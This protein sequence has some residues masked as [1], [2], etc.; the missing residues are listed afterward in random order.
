M[1]TLKPGA[2]PGKV[3]LGWDSFISVR[4]YVPAGKS[5]CAQSKKKGKEA[6]FSQEEIDLAVGSKTGHGGCYGRISPD[7]RAE[8]KRTFRIQ[9]GEFHVTGSEGWAD[10]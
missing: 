3:S 1:V 10:R 7:Y 5:V 9:D 4:P 2:I 6:G 8:H